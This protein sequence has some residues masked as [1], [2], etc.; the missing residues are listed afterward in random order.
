MKKDRYPYYYFILWFL[1]DRE[2]ADLSSLERK[3]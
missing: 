3:S 2:L 1:R